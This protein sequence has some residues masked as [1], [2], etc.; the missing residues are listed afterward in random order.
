M[1]QAAIPH[2]T[3]YLRI[4]HNYSRLTIPIF[5][6]I[7]ILFFS[8]WVRFDG[9]TE[10]GLSG[11]DT[12]RQMR[13]AKL[14]ADGQPPRFTGIF[15]RPVSYFLQGLA[16]KIFGYTDYSI[17]ILHDFMDM[18]NIFLIFLLAV[19]FAKN[20]WVGVASSLLYAFL[21][22]V[23]YFCRSE[24]VHV[25]STTFVLLALFFFILFDR[26]GKKGFKWYLLLF[27]AGLNSGLAA[28]THTDLAFLAPGY[29]LYLFIKSYSSQNKKKSFK[30]FLIH[31]SIFSFSFFTP[32]LLGF[33]IFGTEKVF[34]IMLAGGKIVKWNMDNL[35]NPV[36]KP[37]LF[38]GILNNSLNFHFGK[39]FFFL[40]ILLIGVIFIMIY[41]IIKKQN[42]PLYAYF[43]LILIL[44]YVFF[45]SCFFSGVI[46][47]E[48]YFIPLLPL[49]IFIVTLWY[50]KI[51]RQF[52]GNYSLIGFI[53]LFLILFFLNA[54]M[55]PGTKIPKS[56][57]RFIYDILKD[58]VNPEN[59]LLIAPVTVYSLDR[60][61]QYDL[62]FGENAVYMC[63]LPLNNEYNLKTLK[64]LLKGMNIRYIFLGK[65]IDRRLLDPNCPLRL[66]K[67][68]KPWLKNEKSPYSLE[69]D[70]R[71]INAYI[72]SKG[73]LLVDTNWFGE[74]YYLTGVEMAQTKNLI[75]NGSFEYWWKGLPMGKWKILSGKVSMSAESTDGSNSMRLEPGD[76]KGT[77]ITWTFPKSFCE[78]APKLRVRLDAKAGKAGRLVFYFI[79]YINKKWE[80]I[81]PGFVRCHFNG[82]WATI[83]Q[84]FV[85][86]PDIKVAVFN[87]R[88]LPG[89]K[90]PAYVD[91]LSIERIKEQ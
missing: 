11:G 50:Y 55:M 52:L 78:D 88:V 44:S 54:K 51:S 65:N 63:Y 66:T 62:H 64:E 57:Y 42:D 20:L 40:G 53:C 17:K 79:G 72:Q 90:K 19:K 14:W 4:D 80:I 58:D 82:K 68:Y 38:F 18:I 89:A 84:D 23:I 33:F 5:F 7:I 41:R 61:Y 35:Y 83:S 86:T 85:L 37:Q 6:F 77:I 67:I 39:Q 76:K 27:L 74:I 60:G 12:I 69:K 24:M 48:R 10:Q 73:G 22:K 81:K 49:V 16:I 71:I 87:L 56:S 8:A 75:T 70:L 31:G 15:Y 9:I 30:E 29:V 25:E 45:Y 43:P 21:P 26:Q 13:E 46:G 91:N 1:N 59:K 2:Q 34:H 28:N 47:S 32:Y 36:S 3:D